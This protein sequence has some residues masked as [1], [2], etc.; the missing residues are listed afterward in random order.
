MILVPYEPISGTY[1][2]RLDANE[3]YF[4]LPEQAYEKALKAALVRSAQPLSGSRRAE[5]IRA[6]SA[7]YRVDP[8]YVTAGNW[9]RTN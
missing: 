8:V 6:F 9:I 4:T 2:I 1:D 3:S 5:L 7:Y